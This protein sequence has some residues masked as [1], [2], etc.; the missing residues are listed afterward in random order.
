MQ[1]TSEQKEWLATRPMNSSLD[2]NLCC[3]RDI[4]FY[5]NLFDILFSICCHENSFERSFRI[6][7]SE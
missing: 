4:S 6:D 5:F 1:I 7:Y 2:L 3:V